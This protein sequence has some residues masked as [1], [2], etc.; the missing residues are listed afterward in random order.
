MSPNN[1][2]ARQAAYAY[3]LLL[4]RTLSEKPNVKSRES[5]REEFLK[6]T[7]I[8]EAKQIGLELIE[9]ETDEKL[10]LT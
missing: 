5:L 6:L 1:Q 7:M 8:K 4:L 10:G 3:G 2:Q 9:S